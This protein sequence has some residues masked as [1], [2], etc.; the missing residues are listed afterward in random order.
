MKDKIVS[1]LTLAVITEGIIAYLEHFWVNGNFEFNM[2]FSMLLGIVIAVAYKIDLPSCLNL[3]SPIP[4][5]G[6]VLTG[7][8]ISRGSNYLY[9]I[10]NVIKGIK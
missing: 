3:T 5:F 9:D 6:S 1:I 4:Y 7:I 10:L 2:L 8:L